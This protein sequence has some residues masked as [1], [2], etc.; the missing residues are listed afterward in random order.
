MERYASSLSKNHTQND[1]FNSLIESQK[2]QEKSAE[3]TLEASR[4]QAESAR[5]G[6][7]LQKETRDSQ[8]RMERDQRQARAR[9]E[10]ENATVTRV[11]EVVESAKVALRD[12]EFYSALLDGLK[13]RSEY[14]DALPSLASAE[15]KMRLS[16]LNQEACDA[17]DKVMLPDNFSKLSNQATSLL[18]GMKG[19]GTTAKSEA[20]V[21]ISEDIQ[22]VHDISTTADEVSACET[23]IEFLDAADARLSEIQG[24]ASGL[25]EEASQFVEPLSVFVNPTASG[26]LKAH[27]EEITRLMGAVQ[28]SIGM[29]FDEVTSNIESVT[30]NLQNIEQCREEISEKRTTLANRAEEIKTAAAKADRETKE[31]ELRKAVRLD[32]WILRALFVLFIVFAV[33]Q[34]PSA[35]V[36]CIFGMV[37]YWFYYR[38]K[39]K[40]AKIRI[41]LVDT[42]IQ[43]VKPAPSV[44]GSE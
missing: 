38:S 16:Q 33:E 7:E 40:K 41:G 5:E 35:T 17:I 26:F 9:A 10:N 20:A 42:S 31:K 28:S 2:R 43:T 8:L 44:A 3:Q 11:W 14:S 1:F 25:I 4:M 27:A 32:K 39:R 13:A 12:G 36:I 30:A 23:R 18:S 22:G 21:S 19:V 15:N 6:A 24:R 29:S 34:I 37:G